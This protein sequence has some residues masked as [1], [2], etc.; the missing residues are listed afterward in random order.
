MNNKDT[1]NNLRTTKDLQSIS[2]ALRPLTKQILGNKGFVEADIILNWGEIIGEELAEY[3]FPQRIEFQKEKKNNGCL[4]LDV[5]SG[6][7]AVEI[8]HREKY[9]LNKINTYF[10][11]NAVS[12]IKIMQNNRLQRPPEKKA[13][14]EKPE[15]T[16]LS[17]QEEQ[18]IKNLS[19]EIN[20]QN[21]KEILIKLGHSVYA[22]NH[23][24]EKK[25]D[26]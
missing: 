25:H 7:F 26:I 10:G 8:Q 5:P 3:C 22:D 13:P 15:T 17:P 19:S 18:Q 2:L 24:K 4:H 12:S 21:L 9:I 14:Q 20:N 23:K 16:E 6:A 11:Y 1:N